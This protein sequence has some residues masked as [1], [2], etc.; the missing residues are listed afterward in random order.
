MQEIVALLRR[1]PERHLPWTQFLTA[2]INFVNG[3]LAAF[4][5]IKNIPATQ[6]TFTKVMNADPNRV[7]FMGLGGVPHAD[8]VL[9]PHGAHASAASGCSRT[10]WARRSRRR[11]RASSRSTRPGGRDATRM[12]Q[13]ENVRERLRRTGQDAT[14]GACHNL[15]DPIG[16]GMEN[17]DG[18]GKYRTAYGNGQTIDASGHA[19]RR[20]DVQRPAASSSAS[21]RR[22]AASTRSRTSPS[23]RS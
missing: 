1:V 15:L 7:G 17:F 21:C 8:V 22:G 19:A 9:V 4:Y 5:G 20:H 14:C 3:P 12:T 11:R 10:C 23:S 2:P 13:E 16:L 6:T 18:I